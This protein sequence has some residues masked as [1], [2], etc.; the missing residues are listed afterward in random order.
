MEAASL[1]AIAKGPVTVK[2]GDTTVTLEIDALGN[3]ELY[4]EKAGKRLKAIPPKIRRDAKVEPLREQHKELK[5]VRVRMRAALETSMIRG[6]L[7][8]G[9]ELKQVFAHPVLGALLSR[10]VMVGAD[11]KKTKGAGYPVKGGTALEDH[12]GKTH[13][14]K[15]T[16]ALKIA[17]PVD[18]LPAKS[19]SAWQRDCFARERIQPFKQVFRELYSVSAAEKQTKDHSQRY[20]GQQVNP[21]QAVGV[22]GKRGWVASEGTIERVFHAG[23]LIAS[24]SFE[25]HFNTP[26]EVEGLTVDQVSFVTRADHKLV[27]LAKVPPV[28]FSEVMRDADLMVSVAHRGQVDPEASASTVEMRTTLAR[29]TTQ[30]LGYKNVKLKDNRAFISGTHGEYSVHLGSGVIHLMPGGMLFIVPVHA[31]HR[32]RLFLPF[33][34]DDPK[35]AEV[36]SKILLLAKDDEIKD[37]FLME[38]IASRK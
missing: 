9:A 12:A 25:E 28:I 2:L 20:A 22:I 34:D 29:E 24:L 11:P 8:T 37:P 27:P 35:T 4:A 38:Q 7:F 21:R 16:D 36:L 17:H 1:G 10:L 33:A 31:Q 23:G 13:K 6:D 15:D 30:L 26:A 14:L 5:G 19:W 3:S 18:L 32:G